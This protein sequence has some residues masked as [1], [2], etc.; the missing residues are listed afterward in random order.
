MSWLRKIK[1][2]RVIKLLK[3]CYYCIILYFKKFHTL[4][5]LQKMET[6]K[7]QIHVQAYDSKG[8]NE[9]KTDIIFYSNQAFRFLFEFTN[10]IKEEMRDYEYE[11]NP[12]I[13]NFLSLVRI[14]KNSFSS[15]K[16]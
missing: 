4:G 10:L 12:E 15:D 14:V 11:D 8:E 6:K 13:Y 16:L 7:Y 9:I 3:R 5:R 1:K 2:L